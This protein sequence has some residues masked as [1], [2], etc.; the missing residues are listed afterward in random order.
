[1]AAKAV[2]KGRNAAWTTSDRCDGTLT[3]VTRG[4][5]A[6]KAGHRTRTV[7][8]GHGLL[9]RAKLFAARRRHG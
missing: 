8:A 1:V 2:V 6:V 9:I 7:R 5:V 4:K 3:R